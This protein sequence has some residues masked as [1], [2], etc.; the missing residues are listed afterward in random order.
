MSK[1]LAP[2][3]H[4]HHHDHH[5]HSHEGLHF[6]AH[7]ATHSL[8]PS[9][10][11]KA[12][13]ITLIFMFIEMIGGWLAN[14]LALISDGA[15]MLT[16]VGAMSLS[17]FAL[18]IARRPITPTMT[19]GYHRA[20]ILGALLSGLLIWLIS[21]VLIYESIERLHSPPEVKG[22]IVFVVAT[23]GLIANAVSMW[24]L[25]GAK[26]GNLNVKAA[27][28]HVLSDLLGSI[29]AIIAGAVLWITSWNPID[30]ILTILFSIL[31]LFNS[32]GLVK[33]AAGILMESAPTH[34]NPEQI[35][36]DLRSLE[37]V[38]EVHDLHVWAVSNGRPSL[39]AHLI[40]M[41]G[42]QVLS[43]AHELLRTKYGIIH[44]TLQ[45]EHPEKFKSQQCYDCTPQMS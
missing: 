30:P 41:N 27:Y 43:A 12:I 35:L 5:S 26:E 16:D 23:L 17:L 44:S 11:S 18:W 15:H 28:L 6:H 31:M 7:H 1:P 10:I 4:P 2:Q 8:A 19:F 22:P 32:W 20:E 37:S 29:G 38:L 33:E 40:S 13:V 25:H 42:E 21:G 45:I 39:S 9:A 14:S 3:K 24:T 34:L 36:E